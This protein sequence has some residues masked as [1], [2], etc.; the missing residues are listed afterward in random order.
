MVS[1]LFILCITIFTREPAPDK[2]HIFTP[3]HSYYNII[4]NHRMGWIS[5]DLLNMVLFMPLGASGYLVSGIGAEK[6][7]AI[8]FVISCCVEVTQYFTKLGY[9]ET[10]DIINNTIGTAIGILFDHLTVN[11]TA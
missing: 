8:G 11:I 5:Q 3:F 7:I 9:F 2:Q 4:V 1:L 6:S 10:D